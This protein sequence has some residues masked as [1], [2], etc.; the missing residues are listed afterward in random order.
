MSQAESD[1]LPIERP[2]RGPGPRYDWREQQP[3]RRLLAAS[4]DEFVLKM[5]DV[6]GNPEQRAFPDRAPI[7][8][9]GAPLGGTPGVRIELLWAVLTGQGDRRTARAR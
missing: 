7:A 4:R 9:L 8:M 2:A 3:R 6:R 1:L 5:L